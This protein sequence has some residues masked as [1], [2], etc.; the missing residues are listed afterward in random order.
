MQG[1][2]VFGKFGAGR[3]KRESSKNWTLRCFPKPNTTSL[4]DYQLI[5]SVLAFLN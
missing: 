4:R 5:L 2:K 3:N 1:I